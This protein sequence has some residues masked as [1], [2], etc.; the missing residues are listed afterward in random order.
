[1]SAVE[2]DLRS[3]LGGVLEGMS[4]AVRSAP[5]G[6]PESL[7]AD[8]AEPEPDEPDLAPGQEFDDDEPV[9]A[10][11]DFGSADTRER[12]T[13]RHAWGGHSNGRI[14]AGELKAIGQGG[15]RL[16]EAA[17]ES[18]MAMVEA[19][20]A[21]GIT[22]SLTDSY[23]DYDAQVRLREDKGDQVA[24]ATPGTSV[25]G[26]GHAVDANVNDPKALAWLLANG[27]RFGW[28]NPE[29]AKREGKSFEPWHWEYMGGGDG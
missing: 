4:A 2:P 26:W 20:S 14:P 16:E 12:G 3:L 27:G 9:P 22:L 1:M 11:G 5:M 29:W 18:W 6:T 25:H 17:A 7:Q 24:T 21:D 8:V 15:H 19:A 23:R 13:S 10:G 28:V